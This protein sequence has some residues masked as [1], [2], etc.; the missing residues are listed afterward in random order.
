VQHIPVR[1]SHLGLQDVERTEL[2]SARVG[3]HV[4]D[5]VDDGVE[6]HEPC[7]FSQVILWFA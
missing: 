2:S 6:V 5:L 4:E 1:S 3:V 7:I